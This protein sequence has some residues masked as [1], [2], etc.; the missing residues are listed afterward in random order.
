M[1]HKPISARFASSALTFFAIVALALAAFA[2]TPTQAQEQ[3]EN[4]KTRSSGLYIVQLAEAPASRYQGGIPGLAATRPGAGGRL[5]RGSADVQ[6]Y[7]GYLAGRH[8]AVLNSVGG[9]RKAYSYGHLFNGFAAELSGDQ[10]ERLKAT[11]GVLAVTKDELRQLDTAT[12][13]EFLGLTKPGS[14]WNQLG[15]PSRAGEGV[16]VGILDSGLWPENPSFADDGSF[17]PLARWKGECVTGEQWDAGDCSNKVIGAR[18]FL[19]GY[20][21]QRPFPYEFL[22]AR[23]A[24]GHGSHTASTAAGNSGVPVTEENTF[25][26]T[27][28]GMAPRA[29]LAIYK[30][31]WGNGG[32]GGCFNTDSVAAIEA[33]ALDGVDVL[34][35]SIS[36]SQ[37]SVTD[38]VE[39]AFLEA[40]SLG[41]FVA[42]SAGNSGPTA[43]TV[44]HN[45]PWI[46]TVAASTHDRDYV[47]TVTL[48]NGANYSGKSLGG[49]VG[50]APLIN[51]TAAGLAGA[52]ANAVRLCFL[53]V[54]DPAK[55]AGKIVVCDRGVNARTEKSLAVKNAGGVGMILVNPSPNS[56]N[57]DLHFVPT[58]HVDHVAG[59]A[60]K[61]YAATAGATATISAG[62]RVSAEAP[63]MATFSSRGVN[64]FNGDLLK[65][66]I[67]APGVDVL[68]A[69]SPIG[70]NGRNHDF[71]SGTSMSSPHIAGIA[72]LLK[73]RNPS[74][75]PAMIKS[76]I[77]TTATQTNNRGNP[78]DGGPQAYGAGH[79]VPNSAATP[80]L[81]Y[82]AGAL[83]YVF[84]LCGQGLLT[85]PRCPARAIDASDLNLATIAIGDLAGVQTVTRTVTNVGSRVAT[86]NATAS[87]PGIN[88]Q[89]SPSTLTLRPGQ[90]KSFTV[91]FSQVSAAFNQYSYGALVWTDGTHTV[92]SQLAIRPVRLAAPATVNGS[93]ASGSASYNVKFG[94]A[95]PFSA[96]PHGLVPATVNSGSV[97]QDPDQTF[98][99][100]SSVGT[101]SFTVSVPAGTE[102]AR[103]ETLTA[104]T[105]DPATDIDLYVFGPT[106]ALAGQSATGTSDEQV[107]LTKPA[108][109]NYTVFIH[110]WG[111]PSSPTPVKLYS[112]A[113]TAANAG[114]MT[115]SA[116]SSATIG[117][118][119]NVTLSW[120]GLSTGTR[121][122]GTVTYH[123]VAAP[124]GYDD[125]RIG[126]TLVSV[127]VP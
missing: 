43:G 90:S 74:W 48:G 23:D 8:D 88:V 46:T 36:G 59:P 84:F 10:V 13:P 4:A 105:N 70:Y 87:V 82:N 65:P 68:A 120:N 117:G 76:A 96:Q 126:T 37:T 47:A 103:F 127:N 95:G 44:A 11:P 7:V 119:G 1:F 69:V 33:A 12:T 54:L 35:F 60:I 115:V 32:E 18:Y 31:C 14:L 77:Q 55:V 19:A 93:G 3:P 112:W 45:S 92:R 72:A 61:A 114:N 20:G 24:D 30:V 64:R 71:L 113:V 83:D 102:Y 123:N 85:D 58:I 78:I 17:R 62:Q 98:D 109:G 118:T 99:P 100:N 111:V 22:S 75:T 80:G 79:V 108:A 81:V 51:S 89:V 27:I 104:D 116:P 67:T 110:G 91:T 15:G 34:N 9:A 26:G 50:P 39:I 29:R 40:A 56:V 21:N 94:Y 86:Y 6:R 107:N 52:D 41:V 122:L 73:H 5:D 121:Y 16:I 25:L 66:D 101:I 63:F 97:E 42:A 53:D 2:A 38:P 106:G 57:A 28:S 49:G 125:G 124:A